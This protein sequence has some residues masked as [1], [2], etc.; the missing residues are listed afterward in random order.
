MMLGIDTSNH[1]VY[2]ARDTYGGELLKPAPHLFNMHLGSTTAEAAKQLIVSK[3]GD[4]EFIF[5]EDLFD[6]VA[7][8]RRG[9]IYFRQGS[10][11]WHVYP[12]NLAERKQLAHI[13]Q[14]RPNVDCLS[15]HFMTYGPK[16]MGKD[17][18]QLRFAAIGS[19][20]DF[21]VWRIVSIDALTLGQQLITLQPVLF[22]GI[23]P[24]VDASLIPAE[25]RSSLLDALESVANDMKRA[26]PSSVIDRC[27][28]AA[29]LAL[30]SLDK[31][32]G[33]DLAKLSEMA[34]KSTPPRLMAANCAK[35]INLLHTRAKENTRHDHQYRE[36]TER[37]AELA[38]HCLACIL[39]E[40]KWAK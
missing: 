38:V 24:D 29:A 39:T 11:N 22:M 26:M 9:R 8:I 1:R 33:K 30:R 12:A 25:I 20:L 40:F 36:P 37:D 18:K 2:E 4:S 3:R 31:S 6:P 15:E 17:D 14:L 13:Q 7:R 28:G 21:S 16:Y 32:H 19:T 23:L 5:R 34:E 27:R 35:I 10:Q